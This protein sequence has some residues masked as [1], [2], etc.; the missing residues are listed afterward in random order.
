MHLLLACPF[1]LVPDV[2]LVPFALVFPLVDQEQRRQTVA[3]AS[4]CVFY[5]LLVAFQ[6]GL[7]GSH[8]GRAHGHACRHDQPLLQESEDVGEEQHSADSIMQRQL[9]VQVSDVRDLSGWI[10]DGWVERLHEVT[11]RGGQ[12]PGVAQILDGIHHA[13]QVWRVDGNRQQRHGLSVHFHGKNQIFQ[14]C[15]Q[16]FRLRE[17]KTGL[18]FAIKYEKNGNLLSKSL[19]NLQ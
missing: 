10:V 1:S 9:R 19:A 17:K 18:S 2:P 5:L 16:Y 6:R 7:E 11:I 12:G 3:A 8:E 13:R 15:S 4:V 14:G